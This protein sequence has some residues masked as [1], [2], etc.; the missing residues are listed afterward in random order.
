MRTTLVAALGLLTC[1]SFSS[2]TLGQDAAKPQ[3][4]VV[5]KLLDAGASPRK[6]L[7]LT[8]K[9][10]DKQSAVMTM[11]INQEMVIRGQKIPVP[12][13]PA[14][15]FTMDVAIT[16][17]AE[18]GDISF[19][20][21]YPAV[22]LVEEDGV[23]AQTKELMEGMLK[24]MEGLKGSGVVTSR[25]FAKSAEIE[26]PENVAPQIKAMVDSMKESM[27]KMSSPLPEEAIGVGGKWSVTQAITSNGMT[28]QQTSTHTLKAI[29]GDTFE[30]DIELTQ[31][32]EDQEMK[33]PGLPPGTKMT[34]KSLESTGSGEMSLSTKDLFPVS[35]MKTQSKMSM[36]MD[37]GGQIQPIDANL[38]IEMSIT[39]PASDKAAATKQ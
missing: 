17:V 7:R 12:A 18:N 21:V 26:M 5:V 27:S 25:G 19:Q 29:K 2:M 11:K 28:M 35:E 38:T 22:A 9:K 24:S 13:T 1:F 6:A 23:A 39:A 14:M 34:L 37:A 30:V 15:K 3:D 31:S 16:D 33:A 36:E 20:Y 4:E 10:G 8:S 32:A